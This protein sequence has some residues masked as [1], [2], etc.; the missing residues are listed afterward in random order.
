MLP[1]NYITVSFAINIFHFI[2]FIWTY[3]PTSNKWLQLVK[4]FTPLWRYET[5]KCSKCHH[6]SKIQWQKAVCTI[7]C[8][9]NVVLSR[10]SA[11]DK[12]I[13][14]FSATGNN[15]YSVE[16]AFW[17][18]SSAF[19]SQPFGQNCSSNIGLLHWG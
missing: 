13:S 12:I 14:F 7:N 1:W 4:N 2:L 9:N 6:F 18:I 11:I 17:M 5:V 8:R 16:L 3:A 19:L 15:V 10:N